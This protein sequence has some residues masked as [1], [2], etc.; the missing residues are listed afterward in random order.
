VI[1]RYDWFVFVVFLVLFVLALV[2]PVAGMYG[3]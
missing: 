2:P 3:R 1:R